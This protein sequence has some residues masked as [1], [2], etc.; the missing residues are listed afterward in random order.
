MTTKLSTK[1]QLPVKK[2]N[3]KIYRVKEIR[4]R[5]LTSSLRKKQ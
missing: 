4:E 5:T 1:D 2:L 3:F